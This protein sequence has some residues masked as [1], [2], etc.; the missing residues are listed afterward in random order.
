LVLGF[1]GIVA[2]VTTTRLRN[3][4]W[5]WMTTAGALTYP[6]YLVHE[7][8]GWWIIKSTH[9]GLGTWPAVFVALSSTLMLA[10]LIN[11]FIERP[12]GP[13]LKVVLLAGLSPM[14]RNGRSVG[15]D[16]TSIDDRDTTPVM[17]STQ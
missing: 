10:W 14:S 9:R 15:V 12:F 16:Q 4:G 17:A 8:W 13:K 7:M 2:A 1:V 5:G 3:K 11:R 6:F